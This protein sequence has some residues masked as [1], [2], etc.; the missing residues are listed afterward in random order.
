MRRN[1]ERSLTHRYI[2]ICLDEDGRY[3]QAISKRWQS[4]WD[5]AGYAER[6]ARDRQPVIVRVPCFLI[7]E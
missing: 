1:R 2:V 6:V 4:E 5:A 7:R 3:V